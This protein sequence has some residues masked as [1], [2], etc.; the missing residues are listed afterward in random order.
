MQMTDEIKKIKQDFVEVIKESQGLTL[1]D[2]KNY[3]IDPLFDR[4][5]KAKAVLIRRLNAKRDKIGE[6]ESYFIYEFPEMTFPLDIPTKISKVTGFI[7]YIEEFLETPD[8]DYDLR[9][10]FIN[11]LKANKEGFFEN[12]VVYGWSPECCDEIIPEGMKLL[13]SFK[14][15]FKG[16]LLEIIQNKASM[17]IQENC[18]TGR[19]CVSVHPLDFLSASETTYD[20]RSC[21]A[22]DG[23]YRSGN[24]AYMVDNCTV[25]CY[26]KTDDRKWPLPRFPKSVPWYSKKWRMYLFL[27]QKE[28]VI[29][30]GR[31]YPYESDALLKTVREKVVPMITD[32]PLYR[33][34]WW[35]RAYLWTEWD[36]S[37]MTPYFS[38]K[39]RYINIGGYLF[40]A[41]ALVSSANSLFYNDLLQSTKYVPS[42]MYR[43]EID[44]RN[45]LADRINDRSDLESIHLKVGNDPICPCCGRNLVEFSDEMICVSCDEQYGTQENDEFVF[46]SKCG[47]RIYREDAYEEEG[48]WYCD[49]CWEG[50]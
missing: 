44:S 26:L 33:D 48:E 34:T 21:H 32:I 31:Q 17:V 39:D 29:W 6:N 20:W 46:C 49:R 1:W 5:Y 14:Y 15:F 3:N 42:Y 50:W 7:D 40:G 28:E 18:I 23:D 37:Y 11:F 16:T 43:V 2:N 35:G 45:R 12:K 38:A 10:D 27:A 9:R 41:K 30:A 36:N 19:L 47:S 8:I 4:W 22:L 24:M 13:K 25:M